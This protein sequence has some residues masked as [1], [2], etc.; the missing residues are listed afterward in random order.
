MIKNPDEI[1]SVAA[2]KHVLER[3]SIIKTLLYFDI[4]DYPLKKDEIH[5][6]CGMAMPEST[7]ARHL[8]DLTQKDMVFQFNEYYSIQNRR[9]NVARRVR[10]NELAARMLPLAR[11]KARFIGQFPFVRSVMASGSL[12]KGYMDESSDLDFFIVTSPKRLWIARMMLVIYKRLFLLNSHRYF[13]INYFVTENHLSIEEKNQFTATELATVIPLY[14]EP[15]YQRLLSANPW[16]SGF[17]PNYVPR[18]IDHS[19][20]GGES[21]KKLLEMVINTF[22]GNFWDQLFMKITRRRWARMYGDQYK[23]ADFEIAF[24]TNKNSSKNHPKHYQKKVTER[25][26]SNWEAYCKVFNLECL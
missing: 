4:F 18:Q 13:C 23:A 1:V 8:Q 14:N 10:G 12:S 2:E 17:F 15:V 24:K 22:G 11:R 16:L 19:H 5:L 26:A 9:D 25:L 20:V 21:F 3:N 6:Y 7:I